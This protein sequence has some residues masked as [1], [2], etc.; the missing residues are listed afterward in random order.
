[1]IIGSGV[2][3]PSRFDG[4]TVRQIGKAIRSEVD[5]RASQRPATAREPAQPSKPA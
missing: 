4:P 5:V 2:C 1:M 3:V